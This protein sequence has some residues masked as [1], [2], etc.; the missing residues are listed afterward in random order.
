MLA[1]IVLLEEVQA[2]AEAEAHSERIPHEHRVLVV[3][4]APVGH[5]TVKDHRLTRDFRVAQLRC[6][7]NDCW[8]VLLCDFLDL[9]KGR[10]LV[11]CLTIVHDAVQA[12]ELR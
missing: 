5:G 11:L 2:V 7:A 6:L 4:V 10:L 3:G 8:V 9:F 12:K 1:C